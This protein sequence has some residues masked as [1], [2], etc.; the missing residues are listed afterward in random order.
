[1]GAEKRRQEQ[2]YRPRRQRKVVYQD[3]LAGPGL[4]GLAIALLAITLCVVAIT[5]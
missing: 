2:Q 5:I 4:L 1:M 3:S